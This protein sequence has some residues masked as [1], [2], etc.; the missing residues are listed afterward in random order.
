M[1]MAKKIRIL[2]IEQEISL[3]QLA[4]QIGISKSNLNNKLGR[5]NF[6]E[7]ELRKIAEALDCDYKAYFVMHKNGKRV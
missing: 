7:K 3:T 5:D 2:C 4:E 6:S 1:G